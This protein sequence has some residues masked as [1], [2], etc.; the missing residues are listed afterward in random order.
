MLR[1]Y[2]NS[3]ELLSRNNQQVVFRLRHLVDD[4]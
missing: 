3:T 4:S 2:V 1:L